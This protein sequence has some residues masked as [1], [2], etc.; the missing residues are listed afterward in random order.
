MQNDIFTADTTEDSDVTV[1]CV[2]LG[3]EPISPESGGLGKLT[4]YTLFCGYWNKFIQHT[5]C[6]QENGLILN[7]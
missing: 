5:T 4:F 3:A 6:K 7:T 1:S 2:D